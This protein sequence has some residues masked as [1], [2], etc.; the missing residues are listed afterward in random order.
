M[1][2]TL[3]SMT[4]KALVNGPRIREARLSAGMSQAQLAR[5]IETTE[6]NIIR[7]ENSQNQPRVSSIAAIAGA[8][9]RDIDFFLTASAEDEDDEEIADMTLDAY[10]RLRVRETVREVLRERL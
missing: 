4:L 6:R 2:D 3:C 7:W 10:L 8:T 1:Y 5:A 9:G